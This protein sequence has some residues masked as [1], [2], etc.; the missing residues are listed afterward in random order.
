M[1]Q[2]PKCAQTIEK[3][4]PKATKKATVSSTFYLFVNAKVIGI[5]D[6]WVVATQML[7]CFHPHNLGVSWSNLTT[8]HIFSDGLK[9]NQPPTFDIFAM[10]ACFAQDV[11]W[12]AS[13]I[14]GMRPGSCGSG[15]R[16]LV[17]AF[18]TL[19]QSTLLQGNKTTE[20]YLAFFSFNSW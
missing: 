3:K 4:F 1:S 18:S 13:C 11:S 9:L 19:W 14:E 8:A 7:F 12:F 10:F 15:V 17:S 6:I 16:T 2:Q 5:S 20:T